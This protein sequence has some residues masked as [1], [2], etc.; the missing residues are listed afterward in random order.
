MIS[1]TGDTVCA[2]AGIFCDVN[3]MYGPWEL[4]DTTVNVDFTLCKYGDGTSTGSPQNIMFFGFVANS[5][6]VKIN[7]QIINII[8][9]GGPSS[10]GFQYGIIDR[11]PDGQNDED[12][13]YLDCDGAAGIVNDVIVESDKFIPGHTY[14]LFVDGYQGSEVQFYLDVIEGIGDYTVDPVIGFNV[15]DLGIVAPND[16]ISVCKDGT[17]TFEALGVD[18]SIVKLWYLQD[19]PQ[20][21]DTTFSHK[22]EKNDSVYKVCA[23]SYSD[24][25]VSDT[26]CIF[27]T[28]DTIET[29]M[30][31]T[32]HYCIS[33]LTAGVIPDGWEGGIINKQDTFRYNLIDPMTGCHHLQQIIVVEED[34]PV[35]EIDTVLC[36]FPLV[37]TDTTLRDTLST[38]YGCDSIVIKDYFYFYYEGEITTLE[39][40]NDNSYFLNINSTKYNPADYESILVTWLHDGSIAQVT[41]ALTNLEVTKPGKYSAIVTLFKNG[42]SCSF[43][44]SE[45]FIEKMPSVAFT[46]QNDTIC[47]TDILSLTIDNYIDTLNYIL[48]IENGTIINKGSGFYDI[49]WD[50]DTSGDFDIELKVDFEGCSMDSTVTIVVQPEISVP[51]I[52]CLETTNSSIIFEWDISDCV[53]EYE[54]WVDDSF[55]KT[56]IGNR[57][58]INNLTFSQEVEIMV[59]TVSEC[60]CDEKSAVTICKADD[61][62][63]RDISIVD[64]PDQI[65]FGELPDSIIIGITSDIDGIAEWTGTIINNKGV[66]YK[67]DI[68]GGNYEIGLKYTIGDCSYQKD[69]FFTIY[70]ELLADID[71]TD[72][73]C[74]NSQDGTFEIIPT[75]GNPDYTLYINGLEMDSL[76]VENLEIGTYEYS[77]IDANGCTYE[78]D[79][80]VFQ[81]EKP[82]ISILGEA[83]VKFNEMYNYLLDT[84][85]FDFDSIY[86]FKND[87]FLNDEL[88]ASIDIEPYDDYRICAIMFY[89]EYCQVDTCIDVRIDRN[90]DIYIPNI[91]TPNFDDI[92][93]YFTIKSSNGLSV[94]IKTLKIFDRWGEN[95]YGKDDFVIGSDNTYGAWNGL[96]NGQKAPIGVYVY[97][98]EVLA[99]DGEITKYY[100]DVTLVR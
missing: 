96:F 60:V 74:Y 83:K 81:P 4:E 72:Y 56:V 70:K 73:T 93:D 47:S 84:D 79:F 62:P 8:P 68:T 87:T 26:T 45:I 5:N 2:N 57:D 18:S 38:T 94:N 49:N 43:D 13:V 46:I 78:G 86:W 88:G 67:N 35:V 92:N 55:V 42:K 44:I 69:T 11:C 20:V 30:L 95:I 53:D 36:N 31:E 89:N 59:R 76:Y 17:F 24:C 9:K 66:I 91:F 7:I 28:V 6:T 37:E 22:F 1:Q 23:Q 90:S 34:E 15:S 64:F 39:C 85:D 29:E 10:L 40:M 63:Q 33:D 12:I 80:E 21:S 65:C 16:T 52:N 75:Q 27:V 100:G 71:V 41:S 50:S 25:D 58:T 77:L 98:I 3:A 14:Y 48:T 97:Y 32:A 51:E 61:C 54:I 19:V 82:T 99:D